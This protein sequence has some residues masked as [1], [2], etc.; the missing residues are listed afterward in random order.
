MRIAIDAVFLDRQ[1]RIKKL[2][3]NLRPWRIAVCLSAGSVLELRAG[4]IAACA[5]AQG[6]QLRFEPTTD[7]YRVSLVLPISSSKC[8][9]R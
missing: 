1:L 4:T 2:V 6:D 8:L 7:G 3:P 5:L 9:S